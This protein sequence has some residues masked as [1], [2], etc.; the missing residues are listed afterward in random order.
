M[1]ASEGKD[2]HWLWKAHY[3]AVSVLQE[4][5]NQFYEYKVTLT[6]IQVE[7]LG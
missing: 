7:L 6:K 2:W 5:N 3:R 1:P 4:Q